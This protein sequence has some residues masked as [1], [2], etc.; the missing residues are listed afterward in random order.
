VPAD[1]ASLIDNGVISNAVE[2]SLSYRNQKFGGALW[3]SALKIM[4]DHGVE[5]VSISG[6]MTIGK[7]D[8]QS[9][10]YTKYGSMPGKFGNQVVKIPDVLTKFSNTVRQLFGK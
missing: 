8:S 5:S 10:F 7:K 4:G 6:D 9:S 1:V 2:V 3:L